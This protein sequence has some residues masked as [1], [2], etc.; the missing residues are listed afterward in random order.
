VSNDSS[1]QYRQAA[2]E[3]VA[4]KELGAPLASFGASWPNVIA[5]AMIA[6][7]MWIGG[8]LLIYLAFREFYWGMPV[9]ADKGMCWFAFVA[10]NALGLGFLAGGGFLIYLVR[11]ISGRSISIRELGLLYREPGRTIPAF[12]EDIAL[13]KEIH[14]FER[15]PLLKGPAKLLLPKLKS[16]SYVVFT[17]DGTFMTFDG[18]TV[19]NLAPLGEVL[20]REIKS[21]GIEWVVEET[22]E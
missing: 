9:F 13:V 16:V 18:N 6:L 10:M 17:L 19:S 3:A 7:L 22:H 20:A 8:G 21:R 11:I 12:W 14:L 4:E 15:P 2:Q 1:N 5:G